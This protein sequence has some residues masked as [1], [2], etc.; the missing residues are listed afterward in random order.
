MADRISVRR[1][2]VPQKNKD[3]VEAGYF[4]ALRGRALCCKA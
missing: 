1:I 2:A 3:A 4:A